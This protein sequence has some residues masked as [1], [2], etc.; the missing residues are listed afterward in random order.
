MLA[1]RTRVM[2]VKLLLCALVAGSVALRVPR[3]RFL[4]SGAALPGACAAR[5]AESALT[6]TFGQLVLVAVKLR[7]LRTTPEIKLASP[8][9]KNSCFA[10]LKSA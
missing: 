10:A 7:S 9:R 6:S 2:A 1:Q 5:V 8:L 3:R 4:A